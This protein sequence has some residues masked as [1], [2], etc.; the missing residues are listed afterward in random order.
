MTTRQAASKLGVTQKAVLKAIDRGKLISFKMGR[1]WFIDKT[2]VERWDKV[3]V[4]R[5]RKS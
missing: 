4:K 5:N 1:D 2:E 3:R